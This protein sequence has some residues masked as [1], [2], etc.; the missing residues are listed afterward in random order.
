[1]PG[2]YRSLLQRLQSLEVNYQ[3]FKK[4]ET[5]DTAREQYLFLLGHIEDAIQKSTTLSAK[6]RE[7]LEG[8]ALKKQ[9]EIR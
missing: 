4:Q 8:L 2:S 6:Q 9:K 3:S 5:V 1:M 7:K